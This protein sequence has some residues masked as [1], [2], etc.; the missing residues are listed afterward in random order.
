MHFRKASDKVSLPK[1]R[2]P[3]KIIE[4]NNALLE[5][6]NE[7]LDARTIA[8]F[9]ADSIKNTSKPELATTLGSG[10][11]GL[12]SLAQQLFLNKLPIGQDRFVEMLLIWGTI[13]GIA[14]SLKTIPRFIVAAISPKFYALLETDLYINIYKKDKDGNVISG[15]FKNIKIGTL[16]EFLDK[17]D[18]LIYDAL[19]NSVG[20]NIGQYHRQFGDGSAR[21]LNDAYNM[22]KKIDTGSMWGMAALGAGASW[23]FQPQ[24]SAKLHGEANPFNKSSDT[25]TALPPSPILA[26]YAPPPVDIRGNMDYN[27]R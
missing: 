8:L 2:K 11:V 14:L 17:K 27:K 5:T 13:T 20:Q 7:L 4:E 3:F 22:I 21:V 16:E 26:P 19:V 9:R 18:N 25:R 6:V 23:L 10:I 24:I 15:T 12:A 1:L